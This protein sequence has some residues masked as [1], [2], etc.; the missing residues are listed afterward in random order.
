MARDRVKVNRRY[1]IDSV[2]ATCASYLST[3]VMTPISQGVFKL[4]FVN[5]GQ[6]R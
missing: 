3:A 4:D 6:Y 5:R 1:F 2:K